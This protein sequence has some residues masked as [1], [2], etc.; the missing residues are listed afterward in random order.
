M[1]ASP[2][3][4]ILP[5][6]DEVWN[7]GDFS[8]IDRYIH[9]QYAVDG[10]PV[11]VEWVRN[12]V[13]TLRRGFPDLI[14]DVDELIENTTGAALLLRLRGTHLGE[15]RGW[16]PTGRMVDFR[17]AAFWTLRDGKLVSGKFVADTLGLRI[18]LGVLPSTAWHA[19]SENRINPAIE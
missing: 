7:L 12:N 15:W 11:G 9:H 18:Q 8:N 3:D 14:F 17:E 6:I 13:R 4:V 5:F 16:A 2:A 1:P 10:K 19:G